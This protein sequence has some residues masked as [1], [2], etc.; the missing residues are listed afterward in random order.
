[1]IEMTDRNEP[2]DSVVLLHPQTLDQEVGCRCYRLTPRYEAKL[3]GLARSG[4]EEAAA[5]LVETYRWIGEFTFQA[6]ASILPTVRR[7]D[8]SF[9]AEWL[10]AEI[11]E[12][13]LDALVH[14]RESCFLDALYSALIARLG[15]VTSIFKEHEAVQIKWMLSTVAQIGSIQS[16][17]RPVGRDKDATVEDF[18]GDEETFDCPTTQAEVIGERDAASL[19]KEA[20]AIIQR[21]LGRDPLVRTV[22]D[23]YCRLGYDAKAAQQALVPDTMSSLRFLEKLKKI[24][25]VLR[26]HMA[27]H[28]EL[29]RN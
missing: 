13:Y 2:H 25:R 20:K 16:L 11:H 6:Y 9:T 26:I 19:E 1:M 29:L 10:C 23:T 4:N 8:R 17:S 7:H 15:I 28:Q 14:G 22:F 12:A 5:L 21:Y 24:F 27:A 18:I 3:W